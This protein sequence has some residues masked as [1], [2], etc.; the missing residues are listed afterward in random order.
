MKTKLILAAL[1]L[2]CGSQ[3]Q[4]FS[5]KMFLVEFGY[6]ADATVS[7]VVLR[8]H[9]SQDI[10]QS[11]TNWPVVAFEWIAESTNSSENRIT[12]VSSSRVLATVPWQFFVVSSS[13]EWGRLF[14]E[15]LATSPPREGERLRLRP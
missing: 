14:S 6:P 3:A 4:E 2:A 10:S 13:N 8:L 5:N 9:S 11:Y 7:N 15:V 12:F 1:L